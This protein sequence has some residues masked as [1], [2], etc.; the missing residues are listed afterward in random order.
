M[1]RWGLLSTRP[2]CVLTEGHL[3]RHGHQSWGSTAAPLSQDKGG[4]S[5]IAQGSFRLVFHNEQ[6]ACAT[7]A[8]SAQYRSQRGAWTQELSSSPGVSFLCEEE[9]QRLCPWLIVITFLFSSHHREEERTEW[10]RSRKAAAGGRA[11]ATLTHPRARRTTRC[12]WVMCSWQERPSGT[13][14]ARGVGAT[15]PFLPRHVAHPWGP[16]AEGE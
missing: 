15:L 9:E 3:Q 14:P 11:Q 5:S 12:R 7:Q 13:F 2:G 10:R 6:E 8:H 4:W 1:V 16:R